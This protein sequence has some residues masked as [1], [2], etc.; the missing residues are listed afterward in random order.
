M[1][2]SSFFLFFFQKLVY[3]GGE[4]G[5]WWNKKKRIKSHLECWKCGVLL[6]L[7]NISTLSHSL[8]LFNY[9]LTVCITEGVGP[10]EQDK[11]SKGMQKVDTWEMYI[12][13]RMTQFTRSR[14]VLQFPSSCA[15]LT[16]FL[17]WF[18]TVWTMGG[19]GGIKITWNN[20][21]FRTRHGE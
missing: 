11:G 15:N 4:T 19:D 3:L 14:V 18:R 5:Q 12:R 10:R 9:D 7:L 17:N 16:N 21:P 1:H 2:F 13:Q 8:N 20:L 6:L